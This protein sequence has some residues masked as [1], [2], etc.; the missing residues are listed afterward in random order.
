MPLV[1]AT[2]AGNGADDP[3]YYPTWQ[4]MARVIGHKQFLFLAD[5]QAAA[6]TTRGQIAAFGGIYCFPVA[7]TGQ[8]PLWLQQWVLDP[9][10]E[11]VEICLP[12]EAEAEP[13]VVG[14]GFEVEDGK[15]WWNPATAKWVR[16]QERQLVVYS[17]SD[18]D[19]SEARIAQKARPS[20]SSS[21]STG[22]QT[23]YG[24]SATQCSGA[25][26]RGAASSH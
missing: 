15:F 11:S 18:R 9:P 26:D 3:L 7:M 21:R 17:Q 12:R 22:C 4:R 24:F 13:V 6:I 20:T 19:C 14:K 10:A 16:W 2:L 5:C 23:R 8:I 25:S 1:S